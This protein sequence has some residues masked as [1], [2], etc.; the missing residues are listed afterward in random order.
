MKDKEIIVIG[1]SLRLSECELLHSFETFDPAQWSIVRSGQWSLDVSWAARC[2]STNWD[3]G[4]L[5]RCM[6]REL[7]VHG[8]DET[9]VLP[10][11]KG[12]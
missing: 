3:N 9:S 2:A 10:V 12:P 4:R 7:T 11:Q 6:G 1:N 5:V 8:T